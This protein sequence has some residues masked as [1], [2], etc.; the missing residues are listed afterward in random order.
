M[1]LTGGHAR[2][3]T[4]LSATSTWTDYAGLP[5][6]LVT[7]YRSHGR[8][9]VWTYT[10]RLAESPLTVR[11]PPTCDVTTTA[12]VSALPAVLARLLGV[13]TAQVTPLTSNI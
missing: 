13:R 12:P 11:V 9:G 10:Y 5:R 4:D 2:D 3:T 6:V 7:T 1:G 8:T